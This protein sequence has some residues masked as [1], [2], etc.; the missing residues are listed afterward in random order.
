MNRT[1]TLR[2]EMWCSVQLIRVSTVVLLLLQLPDYANT[3]EVHWED[4]KYGQ[5][6][7]ENKAFCS[8]K[9][10]LFTLQWPGAFCQVSLITIMDIIIN[11]MNQQLRNKKKKHKYI[12]NQ[13]KQ[14][15]C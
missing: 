7:V 10:L 6:G 4:N 2:R 9:C 1:L 8:W 5:W 15:T 12:S 11:K 3:Q 13:T 14:V